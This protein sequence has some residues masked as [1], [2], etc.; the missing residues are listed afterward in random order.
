[1]KYVG[2]IL[3]SLFLFVNAL[4]AIG[5]SKNNFASA[6]L[7]AAAGRL[8]GI[9]NEYPGVVMV[10]APNGSGLCTGAIVS[11]QAV[12]TAT[13]CVLSSGE[14]TVRSNRGDFK[15]TH[16]VR[17][18]NG[19]VD[20]TND[21][22]LLLFPEAITTLGSEIYSFSD[23]ASVGDAVAVVGFGCSSVE[24]RK[25]AGVKRAGTN[26]IAEKNDYLNLL[27]PKVSAGRRVIG[28]ANQAGTCFGDSGGPLLKITG[29]SLEVV[30]VTH[31]GGTYDEYYVSEFT[32]VADNASNRRF[33]S[34]VNREY[35]LGIAGI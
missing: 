16:V 13:H 12:L 29:S 1:M 9:T 26:V 19:S 17:H 11:P 20:D 15:T 5:C 35:G 25:G 7:P 34:Q 14:Y 21:I 2:R 18:G 32:N 3:L 10:L 30:G 31:A 28:D 4:L 33:L 24:S 6:S 22:S 8:S 23:S 27:T